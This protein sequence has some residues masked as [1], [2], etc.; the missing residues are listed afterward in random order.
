M[1]KDALIPDLTITR[2]C[3]IISA[4]VLLGWVSRWIF[5]EHHFNNNLLMYVCAIGAFVWVGVVLT[6][7]MRWVS[8][9]ECIANAQAE[10]KIR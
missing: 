8:H 7:S 10:N 9:R 2:V 5:S 4:L 1:D 6:A 3:F